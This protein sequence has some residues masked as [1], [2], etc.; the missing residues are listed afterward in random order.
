MATLK[1]GLGEIVKRVRLAKTTD[2]KVRLLQK[3]RDKHL[4][5]VFVFAY[6]PNCVWL[7]PETEPPHTKNPKAADLQNQLR[8]RMKMMTQFVQTAQSSK[9]KQLKRESNYVMLLESVDPD[10][11]ELLL[12]MKSGK[13]KGIPAT[14][15][16]KAYPDLT[17]GW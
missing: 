14:L 11:A 8:F 1:L 9:M 3:Y 16:R 13:I 6:H 2:E 4:E 17:K 12:E 10:C 7:L 5:D 15:I